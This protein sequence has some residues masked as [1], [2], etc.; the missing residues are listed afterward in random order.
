M[1]SRASTV[2]A[3]A[4]AAILLCGCG[5]GAQLSG[6]TDLDRPD[7]IEADPEEEG[8]EEPDMADPDPPEDPSDPGEDMEPD[9]EPEADAEDLFEIDP[10]PPAAWSRTFGSPNNTWGVSVVQTR[11]GDYVVLGRTTQPESTD[12]PA[13]LI[14]LDW[15]GNVLWQKL[16]GTD[17]MVWGS[18]VRE[19]ADGGLILA[20][21]DYS[22]AGDAWVARLD[23]NGEMLWQNVYMMY[24]P[25]AT[26]RD[27]RPLAGG[28]YIVTGDTGV[29]GMPV[30]SWLM[31]VDESGHPE[32]LKTYAGP[33]H[34]LVT[35]VIEAPGGGYVMAG[36]VMPSDVMNWAIWVA[37]LDEEGNI[38]WQKAYDGPEFDRFE[39]GIDA[40]RGGGYVVAGE[41]LSF[42]AGDWDA[43]V[44]RLDEDGAVMWQ[45]A[46]G[47]ESAEIP[48]AVIQSTDGTFVVCGLI[49][50]ED[51]FVM[52]LDASGNV[53]WQKLYGG[54]HSDM[55]QDIVPTMDGGYAM[56][57]WTAS[58]DTREPPF[59][60]NWVLKVDGNGD[61]S[62]ACPP[63]MITAGAMTTT[64]TDAAVYSPDIRIESLTPDVTEADGAREEASLTAETQCTL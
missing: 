14:R 32:W 42:G 56:T 60:E 39:I 59:L 33:D 27:V 21:S 16:L 8:G 35:A 44:L 36:A 17:H 63:G 15:N 5:R 51:G 6:D 18:K 2:A 4:L 1:G 48:L 41:T 49:V 20:G 62:D 13:A 30:L 38:L 45:K 26:A 24:Y 37:R 29:Y 55:L 57:G 50:D 46:Y 19:T 9:G 34:L 23:E 64:V 52:K 53:L 7:G 10:P 31:R 12:E 40:A 61:I 43:W 25:S 58:F 22:V 47:T 28:G 3:A 11:D 54:E